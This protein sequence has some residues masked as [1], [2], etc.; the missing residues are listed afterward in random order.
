MKKILLLLC[1]MVAIVLYS[2]AEPDSLKNDKDPLPPPHFLS[3]I[4]TLDEAR[5]EVEAILS[6]I[7]IQTRGMSE[8]RKIKDSYIVGETT[9]TRGTE[10]EESPLIY[11]FNF[12]NEN[13]YAIA[14][15]DNRTSTPVLAVTDYGY[16]NPEKGIEIPGMIAILSNMEEWYMAEIN[17][18]STETKASIYYEYTPWEVRGFY[19]GES[20]VAWGQQFPY[21]DLAPMLT[22]GRHAAAGCTATALAQTLMFCKYPASYKGYS[23]DWKVMGKHMWTG[24][25]ST[26]TSNPAAHGMIARL[27]QLIST[28]ANLDMQWG[29]ESGAYLVNIIHTLK[30]MGYVHPGIFKN[31]NTLEVE[32]QLKSGWSPVPV[33]AYAK[34][35]VTKVK[36]LGIT[37]KTIHNYSEGHSFVVE[38]MLVRE[39]TKTQYTNGR[40][41]ASS[42]EEHYLV[43]VNWGWEG[44]HNGYFFNGAFDSNQAPIVNMTPSTTSGTSGN[45]QYNVQMVVG[46]K[47]I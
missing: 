42:K 5:N 31:Y 30:D 1:S 21:N 35:Q 4:V 44:F 34:D 9:S 29:A 12:E 17:K 26:P 27:F 13:G 32:N 8:T 7:D 38:R 23:F 28:P 33:S 3:H 24:G 47:R 11:I 43:K 45:Y 16:L 22:T 25:S 20:F 41:V 15:G 37:V 2:C 18:N 10:L 40:P 14:S 6:E 36:I 19:G 46:I 39:R